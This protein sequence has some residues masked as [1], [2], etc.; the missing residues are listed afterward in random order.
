MISLNH[1]FERS[2][3]DL[4]VIQDSENGQWTGQILTQ[5]LKYDAWLHEQPYTTLQ[6]PLQAP[7]PSSDCV[8]LAARLSRF[9]KVP[10]GRGA[11]KYRVVQGLSFLTSVIGVF[12]YVVI[13]CLLC[14][15]WFFYIFDL[16]RYFSQLVLL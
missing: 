4:S 2:E 8:L 5:V 11:R 15:T 6:C 14:G 9:L 7:V 16:C 12:T 13:F 1:A 10:S 3:Y